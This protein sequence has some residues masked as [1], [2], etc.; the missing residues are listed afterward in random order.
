VRV[1]KRVEKKKAT[2]IRPLERGET[3]KKKGKREKQGSTFLVHPDSGGKR[4]RLVAS[5]VN[6]LTR[7]RGEDA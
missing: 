2:V 7:K 1:A 4:R 3:G 6:L 5:G